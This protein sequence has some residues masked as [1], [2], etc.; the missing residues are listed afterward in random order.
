VA[1]VTGSILAGQYALEASVG[2]GG[3][4]TVFRARRLRDGAVV[5][6]KVL[7]EPYGYDREFVERFQREAQA[8]ASLV[9]PNV[10]RV[11]DSGQDGDVRFIVM[12]YVHGEDLKAH[13]RRNGPLPPER[14]ARVASEVCAALEYAHGQGIVHR[15]IKPQ[16]ILLT[17]DGEVRVTD[18]GIARALSSATITETGTVL[19]SV[20]Y[21]SPE[22]ARGD[23]VTTAS[24]LYAL[25][26]V[27]YEMVTGRLPFDGDSPIAVALKH[28]YEEPPAPR[29]LNP[30][31]PV[32]LE[33]VIR[34]AMAKRPEDRYGSAA[35]MREDLERRAEHWSEGP[36]VQLPPPRAER[37]RRWPRP[38]PAVLA[39]VLL[40]TLAAG[41]A[42]GWRA[43]QG[44]VNVGEVVVPDFRGR[45]LPE[46][47]ALA[48][49][50]RL[51][52]VVGGQQYS[53]RYPPN[54]VADQDPPPGQRVREG[55]WITVITSQGAEVVAVPDVTR[56]TLTEARL[57]LEQARLRVGAVQEDFDDQAPRGTVVSQ[58][59]APGTSVPRDAEVRLVVSRGPELVT[60]PNLVGLTLEE[61]RAALHRVGLA[62]D[63]IGYVPRP[64]ME[65][66]RVAEQ[67]PPAGARVRRSQRMA[68]RIAVRPAPAPTQQ[69]P[70]PASP[71]EPAPEP[72]PEAAP[73]PAVRATVEEPG[74]RARRVRV[75]V[76]VPAGGAGEVRIV[77]IDARGVRNAYRRVHAPGERVVH[78]VEVEGYA[79]VQVYVDGRFLQEVRP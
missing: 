57:L 30:Q 44:Y 77:V 1:V 66:G 74:E 23:P 76:T 64:D 78:V 27:L 68:V 22:Q 59:P 67:Q 24:D 31:V 47:Q 45:P 79:I 34:R 61:A 69:A 3:M 62:L 60:V 18:F 17:E 50:L 8:A 52:V 55:R 10:V 12:E 43:L 54:T 29:Q 70:V 14:A 21:L 48:S 35:E 40:A 56:R 53:D 36:T 16:N 9:H 28:L 39:A 75:E 38:S 41:M 25:G 7:R 51:Q 13:L 20:H 37:A 65:A 11:L 63:R 49:Q 5:A 6:V 26:C 32:W 72:T 46:V 33:G 71:V 4:A 2:Q 73:S 19:G 15:D 58:E 42:A